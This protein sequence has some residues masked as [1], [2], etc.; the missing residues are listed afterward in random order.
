MKNTDIVKGSMLM[1]FLDNKAIGFATSHSLSLT[2]N[3]TEIATKDHGDYPGIVPQTIG[4]EV[5]AENLYSDAGEKVYMEAMLA[6]KPIEIVFAKA[7]NYSAT[8][9]KGIVDTE[10]EKNWTAG[11]AIAKGKAY[12]TSFSINAPAGDN[13][14]MSITFTGNGSLNTENLED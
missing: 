8:D 1:A 3:T 10:P 13:A 6:K 9:E 2:L 5:T 7:S 14:T 11:E 4:W 12:I